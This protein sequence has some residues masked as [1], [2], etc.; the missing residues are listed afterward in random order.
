LA[1]RVYLVPTPD[2]LRVLFEQ[3]VLAPST[4]A[5]EQAIARCATRADR[6]Q[7]LD[8]LSR[9]ND[10]FARLCALREPTWWLGRDFW[11][12]Q[13]VAESPV[14]SPARGGLPGWEE[15]GGRSEREPSP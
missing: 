7:R 14:R 4:E 8:H 6:Q 1:D 11:P 5:L 10:Y 9:Q 2:D 15:G 12:G 3:P 13:K